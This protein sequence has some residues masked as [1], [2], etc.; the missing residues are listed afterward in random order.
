MWR[1][2]RGREWPVN[3]GDEPFCVSP[4]VEGAAEQSHSDR[5]LL[6]WQP[7]VDFEFNSELNIFLFIGF[8]K[9]TLSFYCVS[10]S[11]PLT[12]LVFT[13]PQTTNIV[14]LLLFKWF[15]SSEPHFFQLGNSLLLVL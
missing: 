1:Y 14:L 5:Y 11:E 6:A 10:S 13:G 12:Q 3:C 9:K 8:G 7:G 4:H 15:S 2:D